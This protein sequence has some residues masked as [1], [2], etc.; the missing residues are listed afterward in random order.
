M[1]GNGTTQGTGS[2]FR[3]EGFIFLGSNL[4]MENSGKMR[5]ME[6]VCH[7]YSRKFF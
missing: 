4:Q 2:S 6:T 7:L 3:V 1:L 5:K